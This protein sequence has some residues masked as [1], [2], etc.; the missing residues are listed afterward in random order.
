MQISLLLYKNPADRQ[1]N[2]YTNQLIDKQTNEHD[3]EHNLLRLFPT[4]LL[5][6][7][8]AVH[9]APEHVWFTIIIAGVWLVVSQHMDI[10]K[11]LIQ[12]L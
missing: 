11:F 10:T 9:Q 7:L 1:K 4:I 12:L 3:H 2:K 5:I 6:T 8:M